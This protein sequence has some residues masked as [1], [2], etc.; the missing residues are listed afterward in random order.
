MSSL[1]ITIDWKQLA[2][3]YTALKH[4]VGAACQVAGIV[5]AD[6]Y[7]LGA[8]KV[9]PI[10][11]GLGCPLFFTATFDEAAAIRGLTRQPIAVLGGL[12]SASADDFLAQGL[13]PVLNSVEDCAMW[14]RA[15]QGKPAILHMDTGMNR[16]GMACD[17]AP[18][19]RSLNL[20]LVMSHFVSSDD[21]PTLN[22][23]QHNRFL[24][25]V[26]RLGLQD[27][28]K[29]IANSGG[30]FMDA[31]YHH[32]MVRPGLALYGGNPFADARGLPTRPVVTVRAKVLQVRDVMAG[33][34]IGYGATH[35]FSAP[36]RTATVAIG[37]ADGFPRALSNRG[38][39]WFDG[40]RLPIVGRV[41]MDATTVDI[42][43]CAHPPKVGDWVEVIGAQQTAEALAGMAG[44]IS[45]EM[46]T[47]LSRRAAR[48]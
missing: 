1:A 38:A 25:V 2:D 39:L 20:I 45:Y 27:M 22:G 30:V 21:N 15:G 29:S 32:Q 17:D 42:G 9:V 8:A 10:L 23:I 40:Q 18:D 16:L 36:T 24:S 12:A 46:F 3:N 48:S 26:E 35:H 33:D 34:T 43:A 44:T 13:V 5:K 14:A 7:G 28:P 31:A 47:Q 4:Y 37:Y 19:V 41:S 11:D 6:S